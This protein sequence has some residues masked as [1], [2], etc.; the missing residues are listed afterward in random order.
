MEDPIQKHAKKQPSQTQLHGYQHG[1]KS[2]QHPLRHQHREQIQGGGQIVGNETQVIY[3][4]PQAP[5]IYQRATG[6]KYPPELHEEG[7][8]LVIHIGV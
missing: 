5:V 6:P 3:A 1:E 8:I 2:Q 4:Q 7:I